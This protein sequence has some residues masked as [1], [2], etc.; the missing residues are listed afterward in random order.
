MKTEIKQVKMNDKESYII[1]P[2]DLINLL[3]NVGTID[4]YNTKSRYKKCNIEWAE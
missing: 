4:D 2:K 1:N 3:M